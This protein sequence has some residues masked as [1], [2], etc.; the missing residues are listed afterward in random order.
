MN[1]LTNEQRL[2]I[3]EFYYQN[4]CS[5][6]KVH[7]ALLPF[8][9]QFNWPT[10]VAIRFIVTKFHSKFTL[11]DNKPPT[12]TCVKSEL[13]KISQLFRPVLMMT[14]NYR[15][16]NRERYREMI[17]SLFFSQNARAWLAWHEISTRRCQMSY[18]TSNHRF[19]KRRV[20]W[21]FYFT[22]G[23]DQLTVV[24][25]FNIFVWIII[26]FCLKSLNMIWV[27]RVFFI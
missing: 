24:M 26:N 7:S 22:F 15:F 21:T 2:Q 4:A 27:A 16:V 17:F 20:R 18:S 11:L 14:I 6:K 5:V 9:G 10:E 13:K 12:L 3:I 25:N 19:I 1:R 8:Y 23:I